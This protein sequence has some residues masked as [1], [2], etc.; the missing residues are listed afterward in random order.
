MRCK[1]FCTKTMKS[2]CTPRKG[3]LGS[4]RAKQDSTCRLWPHPSHSHSRA[5]ETCSSR[6]PLQPQPQVTTFLHRASLSQSAFIRWEHHP[7]SLPADAGWRQLLQEQGRQPLQP[8]VGSVSTA[9]ASLTLLPPARQ[10]GFVVP[11]LA[12]P[13]D[14]ITHIAWSSHIP[15][16]LQKLT[17]QKLLQTGGEIPTAFKVVKAS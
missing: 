3:W 2:S 6:A 15:V 12:S 10:Q 13:S 4:A 14:Q 7:T 16:K 1:P 5:E 8:S 9:F 11:S 17:C